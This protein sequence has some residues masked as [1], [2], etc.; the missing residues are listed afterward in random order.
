MAIKASNIIIG[1]TEVEEFVAPQ[2]KKVKEEF[3][4]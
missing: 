1:N 4:Q 3:K 2:P